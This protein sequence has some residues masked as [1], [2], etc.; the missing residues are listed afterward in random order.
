VQLK[1]KEVCQEE[2]LRALQKEE[3]RRMTELRHEFER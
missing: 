2:Y 3:D 1:E